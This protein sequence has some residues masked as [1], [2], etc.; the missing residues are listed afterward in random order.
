[1][2]F[3]FL[4][5]ACGAEESAAP[6]D[7][8]AQD[9]SAEDTSE[10]GGQELAATAP[11][12]TF[13]FDTLPPGSVLPD[14]ETCAE[15]VR[16]DTS[17]EVRPENEGPNRTTVDVTVER[18][19]GADD[20]WNEAFAP[21]ISGDFTGT[22]EELLRWA[23][24]KWGFNEDTTRARAVTEST[25]FAATEGDGTE[26]AEACAIL[27]LEAP[28]FQ[29]YGLLQVKGTI[30]LGTYPYAGESSAFGIDY[31]MAWLRAC[32][33]GSFTWLNDYAPG[34]PYEAG[35]EFGCVGAWFSGEWW[36]QPANDY[37]GTVR[38]HIN[39]RT[40]EQY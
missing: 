20:V 31:A 21:R 32:Y 18:I 34:I 24:C 22:T 11:E 1:M 17:I 23:S 25:W 9:S 14:G 8:T 33:E 7:T 36:D 28:C 19:D 35:N 6:S 12:P 40:W 13:F 16:A 39:N 37:V 2:T 27:D 29:S 5:A 15:R 26:D 10:I 3:A 38:Y 30:H 4:V